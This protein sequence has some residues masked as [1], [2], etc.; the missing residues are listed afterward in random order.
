MK[1]VDLGL[2]VYW[3]GND[4]AS[5]MLHDIGLM[6]MAINTLSSRSEKNY[7]ENW[8]NSSIC[9]N[10]HS[11][12]NNTIGMKWVKLHL[13]RA[14]WTVYLTSEWLS[15]CTIIA[16]WKVQ[17]YFLSTAVLLV[18]GRICFSQLSSLIYQW[19][20]SLLKQVRQNNCLSGSA[21]FNISFLFDNSQTGPSC[22]HHHLHVA[23]SIRAINLRRLIDWS[24]RLIPLQF[25]KPGK[26]LLPFRIHLNCRI[27]GK[28]LL[29][30]DEHVGLIMFTTNPLNTF[31]NMQLTRLAF[32]GKIVGIKWQS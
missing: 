16:A 23:T 15:F 11:L 20:T 6:L 4:W 22:S 3:R 9:R 5:V 27:S 32:S 19:T 1:L 24:K 25:A 13:Y 21:F 12:R 2:F 26:L 29:V 17:R 8:L 10:Y 18:K 28:M 30:H 7:W 14:S 31:I